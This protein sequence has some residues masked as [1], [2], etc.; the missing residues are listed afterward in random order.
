MRWKGDVNWS[1]RGFDLT[2]LG[3]VEE[4]YYADKAEA[5]KHL[6]SYIHDDIAKIL[7]HTFEK[8]YKNWSN[9]LR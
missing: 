6:K 4:N 1:P 3:A 5:I 7:P 8:V 2:P 9:R